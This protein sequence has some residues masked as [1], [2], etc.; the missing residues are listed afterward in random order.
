M[1]S[2]HVAVCEEKRASDILGA[3]RCKKAKMLSS[4]RTERPDLYRQGIIN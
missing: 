2:G 3:S 1:L 4:F